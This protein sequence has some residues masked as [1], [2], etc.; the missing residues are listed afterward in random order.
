MSEVLTTRMESPTVRWNAA[1][2]AGFPTLGDP[3]VTTEGRLNLVCATTSGAHNVA[4]APPK[5]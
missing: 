5:L 4:S 2:N 3:K 1:T